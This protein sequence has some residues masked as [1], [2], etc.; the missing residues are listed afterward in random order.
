MMLEQIRELDLC[1]D[2]SDWE[3]EFISGLIDR[4][5]EDGLFFCL[6]EREEDRLN[7]M[8]EKYL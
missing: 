5:E 1:D 4:I 7:R 2:L 6:S 8:V 3:V